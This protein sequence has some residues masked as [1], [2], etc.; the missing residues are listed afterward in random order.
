MQEECIYAAVSTHQSNVFH[1]PFILNTTVINVKAHSS[2]CE[3]NS[4]SIIA[5]ERIICKKKKKCI[6]IYGVNKC[7]AHIQE[8]TNGKQIVLFVPRLGNEGKM[9]SHAVD[10]KVL[11]IL[12]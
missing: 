5:K 9:K 7:M 3:M 8:T 10:Y 12:K 1:I 4:S 6:C 2:S 11:F